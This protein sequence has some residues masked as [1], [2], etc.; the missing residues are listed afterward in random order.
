MKKKK[1]TKPVEQKAE[2]PEFAFKEFTPEE[3]KIYNETVEQYREGV[4][5][6]KALKEIY[7]GVSLEDKELQ[8]IIEADFLKILIAELHFAKGMSLD[9]LAKSLSISPEVVQ[10][11]M[12]RMLQEVGMTAANQLN[13]EVGG[14][15][16]KTND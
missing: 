7:E 2:M 16:E 4:K 15:T 9:E 12:K 8:K 14:D 1:E 6:G 5:Q 10:D 3:D 13:Q 11:T